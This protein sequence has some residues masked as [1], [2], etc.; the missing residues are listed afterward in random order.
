[1]MI[2]IKYFGL[3]V[4]VTAKNEECISIDSKEI[5][6]YQLKSKLEKKYPEIKNTIYSFAIN[7]SITN[8]NVVLK[9]NDEIALLPPFAGG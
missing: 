5:T 2:L 1:M 6:L 8:G 3:L 9:N 4:D 7:Q